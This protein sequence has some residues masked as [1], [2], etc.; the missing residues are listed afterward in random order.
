ML[1]RIKSATNHLLREKCSFGVD[2]Q[3]NKKGK[4]GIA[5]A[6]TCSGAV[7]AGSSCPIQ[8]SGRARLAAGWQGSLS[9]PSP[10]MAAPARPW[11]RRLHSP[12]GALHETGPCTCGF[13]MEPMP[14]VRPTGSL[15]L[16]APVMEGSN[17][18]WGPLS[19]YITPQVSLTIQV[20]SICF[21]WLNITCSDLH[22]NRSRSGHS[23]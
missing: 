21:C 18:R 2:R 17:L 4:E 12:A 14:S 3:K 9:Q 15:G 8:Q 13:H 7:W 1:K 10:A 22:L 5:Q 6:N 20:L 16:G 11:D 23:S 19:P